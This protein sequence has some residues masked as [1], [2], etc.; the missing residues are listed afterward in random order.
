MVARK[1]DVSG[2]VVAVGYCRVST[3]DQGDSGLGLEAQNT[4]IEAECSRRGWRLSSVAVDVASGKSTNGRHELAATLVALDAGK[5]SLLIVAKLDR[6]AR[7]IVDFVGIM[8]RAKRHGWSIVALDLNIDT[9][10]TNGRLMANMFASLAEWEREVIGQRTSDALQAKKA[11]GVRLG[12]PVLLAPE[13]RRRIRRAHDRGESLSAIARQLN[14]DGVPT[15][16]GGR[17]WY[18]ATVRKVLAST[19]LD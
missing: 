13:V 8:D 17:A 4:A 12:R 1:K 11:Q 15:A 14:A 5:A 19:A 6:L 3:R 16:Q 2:P 9:T 7:S 10:T 18:P